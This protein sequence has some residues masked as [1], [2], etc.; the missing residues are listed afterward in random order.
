MY[1]SICICM[2]NAYAYVHVTVL[3]MCL[4]R[5]IHVCGFG[6]VVYWFVFNPR[7]TVDHPSS[8]HKRRP[9]PHPVCRKQHS[10]FRNI[11]IGPLEG[12]GRCS[13]HYRRFFFLFCCYVASF[14]ADITGAG[15]SLAAPSTSGVAERRAFL[16]WHRGGLLSRLRSS[17]SQ[18]RL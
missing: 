12:G 7:G 5:C 17:S 1:M 6:I 15:S 8:F 10:Q 2:C 13:Q 16:L 14:R 11:K 9:K 3:C 18:S 4:C